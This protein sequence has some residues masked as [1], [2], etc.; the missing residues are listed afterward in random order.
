MRYMVRFDPAMQAEVRRGLRALGVTP[1]RKVW[2][3]YVVDVPSELV[4]KIRE[5]PGVI[6]VVPERKYR[7]AGFIPV[8]KK[9]AQLFSLLINPA[10]LPLALMRSAQLDAGKYYWVTGESRKAL[11]A[12]E[13][14]KLGIRGEGVKVAILDSVPSYSPIIIKDSEGYIH[15]VPIEEFWDMVEG[16]VIHTERGEEIKK[17][18]GYWVYHGYIDKPS[19]T[20]I[21]YIIRHPY[22]GKLIRINTVGGVVDVSPNHSIFRRKGN[23]TTTELVDAKEIKVGDRVPLGDLRGI[24]IGWIEN[25]KAEYFVGTEELAWF[26][27]LFAAEGSAYYLKGSGSYIVSI[28]NKNEEVI[29][30]CAEI[31]RKYFNKEPSITDSGNGVKNVFIR[32]KPLYRMFRRMF[33]TRDGKKKVPSEILNAPNNIRLAFLKGYFTGDGSFRKGKFHSFTSKSWALAEGILFLIAKTTGQSQTVHVRMDKPEVVEV[34]LTEGSLERAK[35]NPHFKD[36]ELVKKVF[37]IK[38]E[39]YLYDLSTEDETFATGVGGIRVHNTGIDPT[40]EDLLGVFGE[41]T[42]EAQ[43]LPWDENGHSTHVASTCCGRGAPDPHGK[44][45]GV[46]PKAKVRAFKCLG[47]GVGAGSTS[48]I[49]EAILKA[50]QW[51]AKVINMSLGGDIGPGERHNEEADPICRAIR[52]VA[53]DGVI[54]VVAAGNSGEGYA[55]TPGICREA[56]TVGAIDVEGKIADFS[57]HN[58]PDYLERQKPEVVAPGVNIHATTATGSLIDIM[59][60]M[61]G[62]RR[63]CISG[64][65]MATPHVSGLVALWVS[66]LRKQGVPDS[67]INVALVKDIIRRYGKGWDSVYGHGTPRFEWVVQY[68]EEVFK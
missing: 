6:E 46:A 40:V 9:L 55:S 21:K 60:F 31:F 2:D 58:H 17:V 48:D 22:K 19:F 16:E 68:Y 1:V 67:E 62:V 14:D 49:V 61:D 24:S 65:S 52:L 41:S 39:G 10:T 35:K 56:I 23:S 27:G 59:Q 63:G 64:T 26:Y 13:A 20:K 4:A 30:K 8:E 5:I 44:L 33:Y 32:S 3:Y 15:V 45:L 43:P 7:I 42:I 25:N 50:W 54:V 57:S 47:M 11:G 18:E 34:F 51:G 36:R 12:D 66:Y 29:T 38:Y 28:S 53:R 37:E